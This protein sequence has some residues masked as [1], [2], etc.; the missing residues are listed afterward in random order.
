MI[1]HY[2]IHKLDCHSCAMVIEGVCE[3]TT[4]VQKAEVNSIQ[5]TLKVEHDESVKPE[6]LKQALKQE[7][8]PVEVIS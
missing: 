5:R 2:K 1:T 3:D 6:Q 8:Y 7:G 4:G